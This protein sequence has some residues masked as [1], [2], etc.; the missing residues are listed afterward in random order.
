MM[1]TEPLRLRAVLE[2]VPQAM[3]YVTQWAEAAG[4]EERGTYEIQLAVDEA[5]AN[6]V[7][8]AYRGM[9]PGMLE[10]SCWLDDQGLTIQVCD[11]GRS[12]D[13]EGV[14]E[15]DVEAPLEERTLGGLGLFLVRQVM[16]EVEFSFDPERGNRL[17]MT[18]RKQG[19]K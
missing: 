4:F 13:P 6:V 18:K 11:W 17:R 10:V 12:F 14:E 7:D 19:A 15:P 2:N 9:E 16:D 8:H 5:C 1:Q 3:D